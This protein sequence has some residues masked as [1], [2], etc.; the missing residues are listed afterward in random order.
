MLTLFCSRSF[1]APTAKQVSSRRNSP[2]QLPIHSSRNQYSAQ[3]CPKW[4]QRLSLHAL[5]STLSFGL[6]LTS[7]LPALSLQPSSPQSAPITTTT[8]LCQEDEYDFVDEVAPEPVT[9]EGIVEEAWQIVNDT[10]IDAGRHQWSPEMWLFSKMARYDVTGVGVNLRE[11]P[12]VNGSIKLKVL[13]IILDGPAHSAGIRQGDE[14]V[15]VNGVDIKGKSAFEV[16][17]MLQG[18]NETFVTIEVKHGNCGP[19]QSFK[20][21]RQVIARTPVFYRLEPI[22]NG[23]AS[24]GYIRLKEFNALARK[25]LVI[26]MNHLQDSGASYFVLDLRGNLGGLVQVSPLIRCR[27]ELLGLL[28]LTTLKEG[29]IQ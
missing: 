5:A 15:S 13:G 1:P 29:K 16:S 17:S 18:P 28:S 6:I 27:V 7:P 19:I 20:V 2:L 25:D 8:Q 24:I 3:E 23:T 26:A 4:L 12:D 10:F 21:Q 14:V 22:G 9:N 11:I